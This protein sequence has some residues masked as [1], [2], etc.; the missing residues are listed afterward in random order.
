M[1][2]YKEFY[3]IFRYLTTNALH[4]SQILAKSPALKVFIFVLPDSKNLSTNPTTRTTI[5]NILSL[6]CYKNKNLQGNIRHF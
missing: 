1:T 5:R 4:K 2:P 3:R 6:K